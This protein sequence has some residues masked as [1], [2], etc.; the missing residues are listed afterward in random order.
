MN[1]TR[2]LRLTETLLSSTAN[3][4]VRNGYQV[5]FD[6]SFEGLSGLLQYFDLFIKKEKEARP[7][8]VKDWKRT[9]GVNMVIK[10][11]MAAKD[12]RLNRPIVVAKKFSEHAKA[13]SHRNK[14]TLLTEREVNKRYK[15]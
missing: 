15:R 1:T 10:A 4:Y 2:G 9:V 5:E 11:D 7:V 3:F 13:Y 12:A 14:V 6:V 8:S